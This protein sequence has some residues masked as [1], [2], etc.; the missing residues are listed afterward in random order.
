MNH[1]SRPK[2]FGEILDQTFRITKSHFS[3]FFLI[4]LILVGP[5]LLL[6][7]L[8]NLAYGVSFFRETVEGNG[9]LERMMNRLAL[10]EDYTELAQ[11]SWI[12]LIQLI[13]FIMYPV[14]QAAIIFGVFH[15]KNG[16]SFSTGSLIKKSF[17]RFWSLIGSS[18]LYFLMVIGIIIL[19]F[20]IFFS[21]TAMIFGM[22]ESAAFIIIFF[23]LVFIGFAV[24]IGYLLTRWSMY[25]A[26]V[27]IEREA[28]GF[29]RSWRLTKG[30]G[31]RVLGLIIVVALISTIVIGGIE[32]SF[33][34]FLGNSVV[35]QLIISALSL[36]LTMIMSILIAVIFFDLKIRQDADDLDQ[37]LDDYE[38]K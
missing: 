13:S 30:N 25:L 28:P 15:L 11:N 35:M 1:F 18:I 14:A 23:L 10:N 9:V 22:A 29:G 34:A 21:I 16:E 4:V 12:S 24:G 6:E 36:V 37:M 31:W 27:A 8:V 5:F 3:S 2:G 17:S 32:M 26:A 20:I 38:E 7:A 33:S 19:P